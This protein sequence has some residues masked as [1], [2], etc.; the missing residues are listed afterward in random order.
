MKLTI[1]K[2]HL[3]NKQWSIPISN[4]CPTLATSLS[5]DACDFNCVK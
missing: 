4:N 3:G 1:I 5:I 2:N